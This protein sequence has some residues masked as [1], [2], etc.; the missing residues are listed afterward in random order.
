[1]KI[2]R[3]IL[4][5]ISTLFLSGC[6]F[7][8]AADVTPPPGYQQQPVVAAPAESTSGP[9]FPLIP[10][11][12]SAGAA[13]YAEKCAPC[14]GPTG[15]GDG[16]KA[17]DLPNPATAIGSLE[18]ARNSTPGQWFKIVTQ[19]DLERYMPPFSSLTDRQRWDVIAFVY[20]LSST[21]QSNARGQAIY[22][23]NC[24]QCHGARGEGDGPLANGL[25]MPDF[26]RQEYMAGRSLADFFAAISE[27][28]SPGMPA[29]GSQF[30]EQE[31]WEVSGYIRS[32]S[33]TAAMAAENA[34]TPEPNQEPVV[35]ETSP[36]SV[37]VPSQTA[38]SDGSI[39]GIIMNAS[40]GL[41]PEG[42]EV[43]LHAFDQMQLVFT[44][45]TTIQADGT[46]A[47]DPVDL[48]PGRSFLSTID[49]DGAVYSSEFVTADLAN[50][51]IE[52][53]IQVYDTTD[54]PS[55]LTVDR[56]HFFFE[57]I[58]EQ[59]VRV[60]E[61]YVISN[62][63]KLTVRAKA[64][65][66][67]VLVFTLPAQANNIEFED[68]E[69][70][71]RYLKTPDGFGDTVPV[72]PGAG[73]YQ[74]LVAY[75]MPYDKKLELTRPMSMDT[76]AVVILAPEESI[77]VKGAGIEDAGSRDVQGTLYHMY[78]GTSLPKGSELSLTVTGRPVSA[79][80]AVSVN[81]N[82]NLIIGL[83]AFGVVLILAGLWL[84]RRNKP[85]D[86]T[87]NEADREVI[88][89]NESAESVMD[90]ILA[91]DDLFQEGELPE[92]AYLQRRGE[93][94][95]RLKKLTSTESA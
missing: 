13:I 52:L 39:T 16:D 65:G 68:G 31:R 61:L 94:K 70:G 79:G 48:E 62:P 54:D 17:Q 77:K 20:R 74:V 47:F 43:M 32:L 25:E 87:E 1:M 67:P 90:A 8:L 91:L 22:A 7:T 76:K 85:E 6:N 4:A 88:A 58:D 44:A 66:Q 55:E 23:E 53:P 59:T 15:L 95:A 24:T 41:V 82:S 34:V 56:L 30:S 14:H 69:L 10:P 33:F 11:D 93:L 27:G 12:P 5:G 84:Y 73:E 36:V 83:G 21:E 26:T 92:E 29:F 89:E 3:I 80:T 35:A 81:S 2:K 28:I 64:E 86:E 63:T 78:S 42:S 51:Q 71:G 72:R 49:Y 40:G 46:Y 50:N 60:I 75:Q 38:S 18:V 45:T 19:G 9:F 57:F 37:T